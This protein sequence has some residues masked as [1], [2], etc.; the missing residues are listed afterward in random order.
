MERAGFPYPDGLPDP[1][2]MVEA[3]SAAPAH[4]VTQPL[5]VADCAPA[6]ALAPSSDRG[7]NPREADRGK[8]L[9]AGGAQKYGGR[10]ARGYPATLA[11]KEAKEIKE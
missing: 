8:V 4:R 10:E 11:A 3:E 7:P 5:L 1:L 6:L 2:G 9:G